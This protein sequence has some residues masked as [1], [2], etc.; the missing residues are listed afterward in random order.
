MGYRLIIPPAPRSFGTKLFDV[1]V[2]DSWWVILFV[3]FSYLLYSQ[4][5]NH[6]QQIH[7]ELLGR[8]QHLETDR[9]KLIEER[10]DL[11]LQ[12]ES[13]ND[14]AWIEMVLMKGIGVVP[15]G[16]IKVFFEKSQ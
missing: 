2:L 8:L 7:R 11:L 1:L 14:P 10:E 5:I 15:D 12:L 6:K 4:G 13:Q 3:A 9:K 16:Q